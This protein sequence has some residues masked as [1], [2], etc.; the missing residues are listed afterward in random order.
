MSTQSADIMAYRL[1]ELQC[2]PIC[3]GFD[4]A[5]LQ[6]I[7]HYIFQ[8]L[9]EGAGELRRPDA[10]D[11]IEVN[12]EQSLNKVLDRLSTDNFLRGLSPEEW[13]SK[14]A[15]L[16]AELNALNLF[17]IGG[18]VALREFALELANKNYIGLQWD[19]FAPISESET[20]IAIDQQA[21]T[22]NLRRMVMLAMDSNPERRRPSRGDMLTQGIERVLPF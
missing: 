4:A 5:H 1:V 15:V 13:T 8:G 16:I 21:Q 14:A 12:V 22:A 17:D 6:N 10:Q 11:Q 20:L 19:T 3:G 18:D 7:H 2:S 9:H